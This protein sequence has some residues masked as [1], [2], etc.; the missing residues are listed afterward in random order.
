MVSILWNIKTIVFGS[1]MKD[2]QNSLDKQV[3]M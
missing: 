3:M 1:L 2:M